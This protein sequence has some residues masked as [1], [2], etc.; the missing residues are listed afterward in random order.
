MDLYFS[1]LRNDAGLRPRGFGCLPRKRMVRTM[2][3]RAVCKL[4]LRR[5]TL[6]VLV[7]AAVVV[8]FLVSGL[9]VSQQLSA[10]SAQTIAAPMPSFEV[11]SIKPQDPHDHEFEGSM[12]IPAAGSLPKESHCSTW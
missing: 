1:G 6:L 12:H 10:Q 7:C 3:E 2:T 9:M 5:G 11:A 8:W 4:K